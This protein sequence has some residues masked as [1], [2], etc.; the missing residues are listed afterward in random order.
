MHIPMTM[1]EGRGNRR[2]GYEPR[3]STRR[4]RVIK[5]GPQCPLTRELGGDNNALM[6]FIKEVE[7]SGIRGGKSSATPTAKGL[8][9]DTN[10]SDSA[11]PSMAVVGSCVLPLIFP[12]VDC[13]SSV[14]VRVDPGLP[15]A[16]VLNAAFMR[17]HTSV[18]ISDKGEGFRPTTEF[19]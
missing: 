8:L 7:A 15:A 12:P 5:S 2:S 11:V 1:I 19:P 13:V 6:A 4:E 3:Y 17:E 14:T 18:I 10:P 9:R 16:L